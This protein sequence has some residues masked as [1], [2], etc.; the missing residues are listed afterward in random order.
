[1]TVDMVTGYVKTDLGEKELTVTY[2]GETTTYKVNVKDYVTGITVNPDTVTGEYNDT[3]ADLIDDNTITYSVVYAKAGAQTDTLPESLL[4]A[5]D[6]TSTIAQELTVTYI[7]SDPDSASNG[8]TFTALLNITLED[9]I[10]GIA[11][12][13]KPDKLDYGYTESLDI[14]GG[15][16]TVTRKSGKTEDI[17]FETAG[18]TIT[19]TNGNPVDLTDVTLD[20]NNQATKTIK[21]S[22][23]GFD[24]TFD[25]NVTN[26]ITGIVMENT[27]K[28]NYY[29]DDSFDITTDGQTVGTILVTREN[30]DTE[31]IKLD[32]PNV[33]ITGFDSTQEN[34]SLSLTVT[35][36][37]NG[38]TEN[39]QYIVSVVDNV[40]NVE[41]G[42]LPKT[43]YKYGEP[44]DVS[45]GTLKITKAN[46]DE[47]TIPMTPNMVTE[48]D[49]TPFNPTQLGTR[50]LKVTYGG[51]EMFYEITVSD[52]IDDIVL[53]PPT[54]VTYEYNEPLD[55][56]GGQLE[57]VMASGAET[58]PIPLTDSRV[59]LSTFDP[60][61]IGAQTI[62]VEFEGFT[63]NFGVIVEDNIQTI[64]I[65][66]PP[67]TQYEYGDAL[68]VTGG[69]ITATRSSG[70]TET[71]DITPSMVS[72]YNP[73]QLGDQSLTV[74]YNGIKTN[75]TVNV[76]DVVNDIS[77]TKPDKLVYKIGESLDL[78]GGFVNTVMASG[79]AQTPVA[80]TPSMITGFDSTTE[81]PKTITVTYQGFSKTFGITVVDP[82]SSMIILTLP[83]KVDYLYGESLDVTGGSIQI[84]KESGSTEIIPMTK[85][86]VSGYNPKTLGN[87][88]LTV[89]YEGLTQNYIVNVEDY[90]SHLSVKAPAKVNYEYGEDIDLEGG[91]VSI[92]MASGKVKETADMTASMISGYNGE[93]EGTQTIN[94]EYKGLT[95]NFK[96]T[97][98]DKIKGISM[99]TDPDKTVYDYN[100]DI[101]VTGGTIR[102]VKSSGISIVTITKDM[103][104]G[105]SAT[106]PGSQVITVSY[107]GFTTKF[108]VKVNEKPV[109]ET[110]RTNP[111]P[112]PHVVV[113]TQVVE[114]VVETPVKEEPVTEIPPKETP[115][116]TTKQE[117][118]TKT[119]GVKD[120]K[121]KPQETRPDKRIIAGILGLLGLLLL[122]ILLLF[123]RN[124]KIFV[125]EDGEFA[126]GGLDKL[127]RKKLKLNI[128][129][130]LDEDTYPNRVK[131]HLNDAI[132]EK[133][134][135]EELEITHRGQV[136]KHTI[137]YND[138]PYEFIL[139]AL[140]ETEENN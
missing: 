70:A 138:E 37:E 53:T 52:Y 27:P 6:P 15:T 91:K 132:S 14:T 96:V 122:L 133:L 75:Y 30:G 124:V 137:K 76:A 31:S 106:T 87:Q 117:K 120:E 103:I 129:K 112:R 32:N 74:T 83:N 128:D 139:D 131:I 121:E 84:T 125:E 100:E 34:T 12:N 93:K 5:Y 65:S 21:V 110:P 116:E 113:R 68:D 66:N 115:K 107:G 98:V 3:L 94:V 38:I 20:N 77:I 41:I 88:T 63:G 43:A 24:D 55:L 136:I 109:V 79:Q 89:T 4:S 47:K 61:H 10:T 85:D 59:N 33:N 7:D 90:I 64:T 40:Q 126:L 67:K 134:D 72:G 22:Y 81:G 2:G 9:V 104:S 71:I 99:N 56:A 19:D 28:T 127:T 130:Y 111:T 57:I 78:T 62:N 118:P 119:L 23:D 51:Q 42:D 114:K 86:M 18:V 35:Y 123:R 101:D 39:T 46:G 26:R 1:M 16:I 17:P 11:I 45:T 140:K 95:G 60:T 49:G 135:G 80:M 97:V 92:M 108:I 54:K 8:E 69:T 48:M 29:V 44:L 58:S 105:Y 50:N 73:N 102:V 13:D 25:V 82:L 36:T